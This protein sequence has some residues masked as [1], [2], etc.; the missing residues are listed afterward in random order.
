MTDGEN[1]VI[2]ETK[3]KCSINISTVRLARSLWMVIE[4]EAEVFACCSLLVTFCLLLV[5]FYCERQKNGLSITKLHHIYFPCKFLR[6]KVFSTCKTIFKVDIKSQILPELISLWCLHYNIW[7][8]FIY[9]YVVRSSRPEEFYKKVVL[10]YST[11]SRGKY[12]CLG[13][14]FIDLENSWSCKLG[15]FSEFLCFVAYESIP[16]DKEDIFKSQQK[17][18]D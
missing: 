16:G 15:C 18:N 5:T 9:F 11:K 2:I 6:F 1:W 17:K 8:W 13:L 3:E 10:K 12:L 7:T 4:R 14:F